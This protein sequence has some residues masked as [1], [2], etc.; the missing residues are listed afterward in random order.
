MAWAFQKDSELLPIFKYYINQMHHTGI[1]NKLQKKFIGDH[2]GDTGALKIQEL[3]GLGYCSVV[4]PFLTLLIGLCVTI[5]ILGI[6][7]MMSCKKK[8]SKDKKYSKETLNSTSKEPNDMIEDIN[9]LL[10]D[11]HRK[12]GGIKFL[13]KIRMLSSRDA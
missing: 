11:N 1:I 3:Q 13:L 4:L 12:L 10:L 2:N 8:C 7:A 9:N 6:E 5:F